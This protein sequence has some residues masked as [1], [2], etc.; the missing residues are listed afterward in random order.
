MGHG[1]CAFKETDVTRLL[2]AAK[3]AGVP[4]RIEIEAGKITLTTV[5]PA[6]EEKTTDENPWDV[7]AAELKR[8]GLQQ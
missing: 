3:K 4:V 1:P 6:A 7:A 8:K 2:R 5:S